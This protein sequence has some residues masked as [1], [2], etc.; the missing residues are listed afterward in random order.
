MKLKWKGMKPVSGEGPLFRPFRLRPS[1]AKGEG[2]RR[3]GPGTEEELRTVPKSDTQA[4][5]P[6]G[7]L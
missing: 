2:R 4:V 7:L 6:R 1:L 3:S 5:T